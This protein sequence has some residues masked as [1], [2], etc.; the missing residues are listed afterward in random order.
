ML[1]ANTNTVKLMFTNKSWEFLKGKTRF[2]DQQRHEWTTELK[3]WKWWLAHK[4]VHSSRLSF[5]AFL[6]C[7]NVIHFTCDVMFWYFNGFCQLSSV[8]P[9]KND[10]FLVNHAAQS[11]KKAKNQI[12]H[13]LLKLHIVACSASQTLR[14]AI[15][16]EEKHV[17]KLHGASCHK[18]NL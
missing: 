14:I 4:L 17:L 8:S 2:T 16:Y 7:I 9:E 6:Q 18:W 11:F 12:N 1:P 5:T 10:S 13:N 3:E 15:F